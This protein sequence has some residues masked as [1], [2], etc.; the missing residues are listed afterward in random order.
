MDLILNK[1]IINF[2]Y[3]INDH[4]KWISYNKWQFDYDNSNDRNQY[5]IIKEFIKNSG[6]ITIDLKNKKEI[7]LLN[8]DVIDG[9]YL[10]EPLW[11]FVKNPKD[12][13][14]I[15]KANVKFLKN[16]R[17]LIKENDLL[18][19]I[20][21]FCDKNNYNEL[22]SLMIG[23]PNVYSSY[24]MIIKKLINHK[25]FNFSDINKL[26]IDKNDAISLLH[27]I[28]QE[29]GSDYFLDIVFKNHKLIDGYIDNLIRFFKGKNINDFGTISDELEDVIIDTVPSK[30]DFFIDHINLSSNNK[31]KYHL[32]KMRSIFLS[33]PK[34]FM[35]IY[36]LAE[37]NHFNS[38]YESSHLLEQ[39]LFSL[40]NTEFFNLWKLSMANDS[41]KVQ[42][43]EL[44]I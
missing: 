6:K 2:E 35:K 16:Y 27:F 33:S 34:E 19:I 37:K 36:S 12:M 40:T 31:N 44:L 20:N 13:V 11:S 41:M 8:S 14:A 17:T 30:C 29:K 23:L 9:H 38:L 7:E 4:N 18:E 32:Y 26:C 42:N 28:Y 25:M 15:C 43:F 24:G 3:Q 5:M 1:I 22:K 39:D 21:F 10:E